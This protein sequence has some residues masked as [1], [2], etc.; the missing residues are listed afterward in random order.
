[1]EEFN[2]L[3]T[4]LV[5][6]ACLRLQVPIRS[7]PAGIRAVSP[8]MKVAGRVSPVRHYGSVDVFFEA[9]EEA[10]HGNVLVI[11][12]GGREDEGC[13]GDLSVLEARAAGLAGLVVWG[14][15]RDTPELIEMGIPVF[16]YGACPMGPQR[17]DEREPEALQ[18]ARFGPLGVTRDDAVF[19]DADGVLFVAMEHVPRV[20]EAARALWRTER[21]QAELVRRGKTLR[22]QLAFRQY[23]EKRNVDPRYTFRDH[24]RT[25]GGAIEE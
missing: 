19:A 5:F 15:H 3:S 12:N 25:I 20:L 2:A 21:S 22:E 10:Q 4:P 1:M 8:N 17:L 14:L 13:I 16:S 11:D 9:M 6:D 24:L 23:L 7:A 18:S